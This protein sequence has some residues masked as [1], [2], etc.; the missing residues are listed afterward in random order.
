MRGCG[1]HLNGFYN[2]EGF[3][4]RILIIGFQR[5]GTSILNK[6]IR[7][8]PNVQWMFHEETLMKHPEK[9]LQNTILPHRKVNV[10]R[11]WGEKVPY[12]NLRALKNGC[13]MSIIDYATKWNQYYLPKARVVNIVR[14]PYDVA[15]S[16]V[17]MKWVTNKNVDSW[18]NKQARIVPK[19]VDFIDSLDNGINIKYEDLAL[20]PKETLSKLFTFCGLL[21]KPLDDFLHENKFGEIEVST[22]TL[23]RHERTKTKIKA[24]PIEYIEYLNN[25]IEGFQY[26]L[27][28]KS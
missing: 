19:V 9:H 13:R 24:Y 15:L 2:C 17:S 3:K 5:S 26:V 10:N 23:L 18:V 7:G 8:H 28:K 22:K 1:G 12:N 4:L 16:S 27:P 21:T 20:N 11:H 25:T 6:L 14:H